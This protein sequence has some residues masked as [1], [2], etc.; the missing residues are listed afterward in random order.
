MVLTLTTLLQ[1][2]GVWI[3]IGIVVLLLLWVSRHYIGAVLSSLFYDYGIDAAFSFA[4]LLLPVSV[5]GIDIGDWIAAGIIYLRYRKQVGG[6]WAFI[7]A[8]EACN[9]FLSFVPGIGEFFEWGFNLFPI[10]SFV[11]V[12]K[13]YKADSVYNNIKAY[14]SYLKSH[15][16]QLEK[17]MK[18]N[19]DAMHNLYEACAYEELEKQGKGIE[20]ALYAEVK[21]VI[22]KKL[23]KAQQIII[24]VLQQSVQRGRNIISTQEVEQL[25]G[26]VQQIMRSIDINWS[27]ASQQ[28]DQLLQR[29]STLAY[30][31][32]H[33]ISNI[34]SFGKRRT[35]NGSLQ[36]GIMKQAFG[37][38][39]TKEEGGDASTTKE[40]S[41]VV[42]LANE[43]RKRD[44]V[45][46]IDKRFDEANK[47]AGVI[48]KP[49]INSKSA[50]KP[51]VTKK[52]TKVQKKA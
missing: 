40:S 8:L 17:Q 22:L 15:D 42:S 51:K 26:N 19:I 50:S 31:A 21:Q 12:Y 27:I 1:D 48:S 13:Q 43:R 20:T 9:F 5:A 44:P 28:A 7:F 14:D 49:S 25:K 46:S 30:S 3:G 24:T 35:P 29:V 2:P 52:P 11:I 10:I 36:E 41:N 18:G 33:P 39:E 34:F 23:N 45:N 16:Q 32:Q 4:D 6:I 37:K 47:K 38:Q